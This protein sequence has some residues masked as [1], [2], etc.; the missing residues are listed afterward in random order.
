MLTQKANEKF[1]WKTWRGI[2]FLGSAVDAKTNRARTYCVEALCRALALHAHHRD[3]RLCSD[4]SV[5]HR[6]TRPAA[7][8][9]LGSNSRRCRDLR[10]S[11][12]STGKDGLICESAQTSQDKPLPSDAF[13]D[14][15]STFVGATRFRTMIFRSTH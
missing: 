15:G 11:P 6:A 4:N 2:A 12:P 1:I 10:H 13:L 7:T 3:A 5:G 9:Y 14:A 8:C